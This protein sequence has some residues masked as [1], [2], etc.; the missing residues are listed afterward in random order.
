[1]VVRQH[2]SSLPARSSLARSTLIKMGVRIAVIIA[3]TTLFSYLH[4]FHSLRDEALVQ[5]ERNVTER[6]QREQTLFVLA[7]DNHAAMKVAMTERLRTLSQEDVDARFNSLFALRPDGTLR[8]RR[9]LFDGTRMPG[10]FV[11]KDVTLDADFRRRL[12]AAYDVVSQYAPAFHVR[13]TNTGI[14]LPEGVVVGYWPEGPN[15]FQDLE[16]T[17][18]IK[19]FEYFT[20]AQPEHNPK[21]E[22]VWTSIFEDPPTQTWMVTV[23]TPLDV[24]GRYVGTMSHDLLLNDLM[25]RTINNHIPGAYNILLRDDGQL[26]AHPEM[27]M[28]SGEGVYDIQK[29]T[30]KP[31]DVSAHAGTAEARAHLHAIFQKLKD[32]PPGEVLLEVPEYGELLAVARL[33][34]PEWIAVTVLPEQVV[35][36]AAFRA[37][38]YVLGFGVVSLLLELVIMYWVLRQQISRPLLDFTQATARLEAGDFNVELDTSRDDELGHLASSFQRMA[39]EIHRREEAL[40]QANE[41]LEQRVEQRTRELQEVH[42]KLVETARQVGRAEIATNVLHNVGNVLNSV[43]TSTLLARERLTALKLEECGEGGGAARATPERPPDL[44]L[45]RRAR[46]E[47]AALHHPAG[48]IHAGGAPGDSDPARRRQPAHRAHWRHRQAAAAIRPDAPAAL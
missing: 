47:R 9:E 13:F 15:Y 7:E 3:L 29:N 35:S 23:T 39:D 2:A 21:R 8:N 18:S 44:P 5:L 24:D 26:I 38:R 33:Q 28:K 11:P 40:R 22:S 42:R 1:M 32:L 27:K 37:A 48:Q 12:V 4:I 30:G 43:L 34:G 19:D 36:S 14:M 46:K 10:V 16:A 41:G 45:P 31:E 25:G 6:S 17:F 20:L